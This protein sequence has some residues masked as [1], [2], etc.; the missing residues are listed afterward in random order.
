MFMP[1][2]ENDREVYQTK[3]CNNQ[4]DLKVTQS[5]CFINYLDNLSRQLSQHEAE[6]FLHKTWCLTSIRES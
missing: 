6:M 5:K 2:I 1:M 3:K 4:A